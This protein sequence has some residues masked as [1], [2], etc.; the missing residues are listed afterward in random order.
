LSGFRENSWVKNEAG[1]KERL[2]RHATG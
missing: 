2:F 1:K